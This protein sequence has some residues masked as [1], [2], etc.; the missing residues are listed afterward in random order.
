MSAGKGDPPK[1]F[2]SETER[3]V[4]PAGVRAKERGDFFIPPPLPQCEVEL[5]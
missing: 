4:A 3:P 1:K 2:G 5:S